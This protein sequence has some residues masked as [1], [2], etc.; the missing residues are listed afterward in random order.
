MSQGSEVFFSANSSPSSVGSPL[1]ADGS[2]CSEQLDQ[3]LESLE[4]G[5]DAANINTVCRRLVPSESDSDVEPGTVAGRETSSA[6]A[7]VRAELSNISEPSSDWTSNRP[8]DSLRLI[9]EGGPLTDAAGGPGAVLARAGVDREAAVNVAGDSSTVEVIDLLSSS[10]SSSGSPRSSSEGEF[11]TVAR[12]TTQRK[13]QVV[14]S[15][16]DGED[17]AEEYSPS[18]KAQALPSSDEGS[19]SPR[20]RRALPEYFASISPLRTI[21]VSSPSRP[22]PK[23]IPQPKPGITV[24]RPVAKPVAEPALVRRREEQQHRPTAA[25]SPQKQPVPLPVS[26][27]RL[28]APRS[29]A[30]PPQTAAA[31]KRQ[32]EQLSRQLFDAY[33]RRI[34]GGRLPSDLQIR[35][36]AHVELSAKVLDAYPKLERTL[37][38]ELCHVAAWLLDHT[39][40]PPHGPM[41]RKWADRA[42]AVFPEL[43]ITTCHSYEI[44]YPYRWQC[45]N[46]TCGQTYGRHSN[47]IDVTKKACGE[48]RGRLLFLGKFQSDGTPAKARAASGFSKFVQENY[49]G[50]REEALPGTPHADIMK[51]LSGKWAAK[52]QQ[53]QQGQPA[54]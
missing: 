41:F 4:L 27:Y 23:Q 2:V 14:E 52:Q 30:K 33:N 13:R 28:P 46:T 16:S 47:S 34:F 44:F 37:C 9:G 39:A 19:P 5:R 32:R 12:A 54:C 35:Y 26:P 1:S 8:S 7:A 20:V 40:K 25:A 43:D 36:S 21:Q 11:W 53:Q 17:D 15:S 3:L 48:C 51:A 6:G 24:H 31:F 29:G 18:P 38:H 42:M 50:A 22:P 49:T 45:S 10:P